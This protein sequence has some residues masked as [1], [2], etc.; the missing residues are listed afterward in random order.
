MRTESDILAGTLGELMGGGVYALPLHDGLIVPARYAEKAAKTFAGM[1]WRVG[2][3][4]VPVRPGVAR[5]VALGNGGGGDAEGNAET[6]LGEL[7][8]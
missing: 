1:A 4:R 5:S 7:M 2:G 8:V 3:A 6:A